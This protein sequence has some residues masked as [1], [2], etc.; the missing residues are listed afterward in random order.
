MREMGI[1][2]T[3]QYNFTIIKLEKIKN[4]NIKCWQGHGMTEAL[5]D[6]LKYLNYLL[7]AISCQKNLR[8]ESQ[9]N[10]WTCTQGELY[11]NFFHDGIVWN[12]KEKQEKN[13]EIPIK[14]NVDQ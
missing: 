9:K 6:R 1:Q 8:Y 10:S 5:E 12:K 13:P 11:K 14:R 7:K 3:L 2:T 4:S